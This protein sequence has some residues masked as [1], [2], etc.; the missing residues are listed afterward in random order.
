MACAVVVSLFCLLVVQDSGSEA[1]GAEPSTETGFT[2]P[3]AGDPR[4]EYLA[5]TQ[6]TNLDQLHQPI[7]QER[8]DDLAMQFGLTRGDAFTPQQYLEF[9][10]GQ[11]VGGDTASAK[12]IEESA[13][14]LTNTIG[15]PLLSDVNGKITKTVLASYGLF[16]NTEGLLQSLANMDSPTRQANSVIAP[17]GYMGTWCRANGCEASIEAL[18]SSA[19][20][21]EAVLGLASQK[22]S[23]AA[24]LVRNTKAG[25]SSEVGMSMV[26][27]IWVANFALLYLLN[28]EVAAEMPAYWAPIPSAVA[29]A[30]LASPT[31]QVPY[32]DYASAFEPSP[33]P[34]FTG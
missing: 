28:P 21:V 2:Q 24:Q 30:L 26:P 25:I 14:I 3:F 10:T 18:Y 11:G 15:R 33:T 5:A 8:A 4:Y 20:T 32:S 31:G 22:I 6:L 9:I 12:I 13:R 34:Q 29:D 16:V 19:Y 23:G 7:G 1:V 17:G 27:S